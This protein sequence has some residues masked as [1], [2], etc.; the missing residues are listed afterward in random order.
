M[1]RGEW[2]MIL[3]QRSFK[4]IRGFGA[5]PKPVGGKAG[6]KVGFISVDRRSTL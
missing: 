3:L 4:I 6:C 2:L 1:V 5:L